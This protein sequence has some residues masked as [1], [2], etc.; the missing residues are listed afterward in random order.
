MTAPVQTSGIEAAAVRHRRRVLA[1][2]AVLLTLIGLFPTYYGGGDDW[3]LRDGARLL[4]HGHAKL[5]IHGKYQDV[6][7][8]GLHLYATYPYIQI[9][10]LALLYT[11]LT[12]VFGPLRDIATAMLAMLLLVPTLGLL[13]SASKRSARAWTASR[14]RTFLIAGLLLICSWS[15]ASIA[16]AHVEDVFVA[17]AAAAVLRGLVVRQ[18]LVV[19]GAIGLA[20]ACKPTALLLLPAVFAF[21]GRQLLRAGAAAAVPILL[22]WL[23]FVIADRS[24]LSAGRPQIPVRPGSALV[25][26]GL[27]PGSFPPGWLRLA[28][29]GCA[30][31]FGLYLVLRRRPELI[32]LVAFPIRLALDPGSASYYTVGIM[33]ACFAADLVVASKPRAVTSLFAWLFLVAPHKLPGVAYWPVPPEGVQSVMA[34]LGCGGLVAY[35]LVVAAR[36]PGERVRRTP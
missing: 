34:L 12:E 6:G 29:L 30:W 18:P 21:S 13:E 36:D 25:V 22:A 32:P 16:W 33:T 4:V 17:V 20:T 11:W 14:E 3:A 28:Q 24:T 31:L 9:G 27:E 1:G 8:G 5:H 15:L 23:P 19:G 26:L 35:A 7:G 2:W 10:P